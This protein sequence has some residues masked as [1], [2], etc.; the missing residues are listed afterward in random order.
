MSD[1]IMLEKSIDFSVLVVSLC[2][3][4]KEQKRESI[5]SNQLIRCA[6]SIGA[7]LHESKYAQITADFISKVQIA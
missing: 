3:E 1:S 6:T 2:R 5:M 7:N 4:V